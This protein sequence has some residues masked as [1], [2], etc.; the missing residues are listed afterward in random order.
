MLSFDRLII[1][2]RYVDIWICRL[3]L[4]GVAAIF[5]I[6]SITSDLRSLTQ[7]SCGYMDISSPKYLDCIY[8]Q[9]QIFNVDFREISPIII[10]VFSCTCTFIAHL[11]GGS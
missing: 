7:E 1:G 8:L 11:R 3:L 6:S 10:L 4:T 5:W 9:M 2:Y